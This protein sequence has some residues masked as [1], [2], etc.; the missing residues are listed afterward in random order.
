[1]KKIHQYPSENQG[2]IIEAKDTWVLAYNIYGK[3]SREE[4]DAY[5][6]YM[7]TKQGKPEKE[8]IS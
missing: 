4:R 5:K 2:K 6:Y 1:M 3:Y 7:A 8:I